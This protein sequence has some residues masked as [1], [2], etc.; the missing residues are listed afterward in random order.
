MSNTNPNTIIPRYDIRLL[1]GDTFELKMMFRSPGDSS[2]IDLS[3]YDVVR[4]DVRKS[5]DADTAIISLTSQPEN[6]NDSRIDLFDGTGEENLILT[7]NAEDTAE[8]PYGEHYYDIEFTDSVGKVKTYIWGRF[9]VFRDVTRLQ[10]S[11]DP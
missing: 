5:L 10:P 3:T 4:M 6:P 9:E 1:R 2:P 7:I 8:L 11:V